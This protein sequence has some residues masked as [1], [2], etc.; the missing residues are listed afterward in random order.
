MTIFNLASISNMNLRNVSVERADYRGRTA[1]QVIEQVDGDEGQSL[2]I[3][4][5]SIF[6]DGVIETDIAGSLRA[7]APEGM[8]GFVGI[9]FRVQPQG[10]QFECFYI[11]PTNGRADDQLRRNHATQYISH[12]DY[13]WFKL[14]EENPGVECEPDKIELIIKDN[15][16]GIACRAFC[17]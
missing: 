15:G 14:R 6:R 1:L 3:I 16:K 10:E 13:P 5:D 12:P 9:A 7:D 4:P 2:V 8:R 17:E 11:R